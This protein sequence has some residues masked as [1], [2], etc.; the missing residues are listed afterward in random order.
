MSCLNTVKSDCEELAGP[1]NVQPRITKTFQVSGLG[2]ERWFLVKPFGETSDIF[3]YWQRWLLC[4]SGALQSSMYVIRT[5]PEDRPSGLSLQVCPFK[6][7]VFAVRSWWLLSIEFEQLFFLSIELACVSEAWLRS[8]GEG[9]E[10]LD[11]QSSWTHGVC[12]EQSVFQRKATFSYRVVLSKKK[13][14]KKLNSVKRSS[15]KLLFLSR[16]QHFSHSMWFGHEC[17]SVD[18]WCRE[19]RRVLTSCSN[20]LRWQISKKNP[21]RER[22]RERERERDR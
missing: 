22:E 8:I 1:K 16:H 12:F 21:A 2:L 11:Q 18:Y 13:K 7:C 14:K 15:R 20:F 17:D 19:W 9:K 5:L 10:L 6:T 4:S 3:L